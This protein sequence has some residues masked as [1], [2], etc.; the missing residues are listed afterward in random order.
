M[1]QPGKSALRSKVPSNHGINAQSSLIFS[2][3][4]DSFFIRRLLVRP[5]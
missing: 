2:C 5:F 3:G 1:D 4:S